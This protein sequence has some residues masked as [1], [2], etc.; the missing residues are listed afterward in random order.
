MALPATMP[1]T[2]ANG[3]LSR[4]SSEFLSE[5]KLAYNNRQISSS[6]IGVWTARMV[7]QSPAP[8]VTTALKFSRKIPLQASS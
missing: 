5:L 6:V 3:I 7:V 2:S 4:M 8:R 1:P